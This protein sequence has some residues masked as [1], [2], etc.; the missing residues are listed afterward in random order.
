MFTGREKL[1]AAIAFLLGGGVGFGTGL[2]SVKGARDFF[3]SMTQTEQGADVAS[4][5]AVTR[6]GFRFEHPRNWR[7]DTSEE[8]HDPDHM[9]TL[10]TPGQSFVMFVIADAQLDAKELLE[11]HVRA[12]QKVVKDAVRTPFATWG[13]HE[14]HGATLRGKHLGITPGSVRIFAWEEAGR[15]FTVVQSTYDGNA[16]QVTPGFELVERTFRVTSAAPR[17]LPP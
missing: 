17:P 10:L 4:P 5:V 14:G 8:G 9:F 6:P 3:A 16:A 11:T 15:T 13:T 7:I 1:I 12:Q 2:L